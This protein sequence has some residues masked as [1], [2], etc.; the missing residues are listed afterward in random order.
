MPNEPQNT[1]SLLEK[2]RTALIAELRRTVPD[3]FNEY[4]ST[5]AAIEAVNAA[6]E[7]SGVSFVG[8]RAPLDAVDVYLNKVGKPTPLKI[9]AKECKEAGFA[10]NQVQRPDQ[11]IEYAVRRNVDKNPKDKK[12]R[13][14]EINGLVGKVEWPDDMF[15]EGGLQ[16]DE[17]SSPS[18]V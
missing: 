14:K 13:F 4:L 3:L 1:R 5:N 2:R 8:I 11:N 7:D 16:H 18:S 15:Q 6:F 10:K 17:R 9:I 12:K